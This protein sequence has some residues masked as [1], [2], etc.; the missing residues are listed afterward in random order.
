MI[1]INC[2][3]K[4]SD[5]F[6]LDANLKIQKG[7]FVCLYGKSGSGKTT[8]LG[9]IAGFIKPDSGCIKFNSKTLFDDR[10]FIPPQ[11]RE[12]SYL[13]QDYALFENMSVLGNLLFAKKDRVLAEKLLDLVELKELK[14]SNVTKLSGGQKQ[15]VALARALMRS[16]EILLLDEPLSALDSVLRTKLQEFLLKI[17]SEFGMTIVLVSHDASEIYRLANLVYKMENGQIT[18]VGTPS[19]ILLKTSGSR[20]L[21]FSA[22]VESIQITPTVAIVVAS[23]GSSL[24]EVVL[25]PNEASGVKVGDMVN[26]STKAFGINLEK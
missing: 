12:V 21:S 6:S 9:I 16:P 23:I 13:F 26:L 20:K 11:K 3:K 17:H 19:E 14:N 24:C 15:R 10:I 8:L 2:Q 5:H 18:G 22:R 1:E 4:L 25:S 7:D